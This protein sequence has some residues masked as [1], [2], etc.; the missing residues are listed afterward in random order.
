MGVASSTPLNL[1]DKKL[2]E[3]NSDSMSLKVTLGAGCYWGTENYVSN[4]WGKDGRV[5]S[6]AVGFMGGE[7]PNPTYENVCTG[8]TGHVEVLDVE[9]A[10]IAGVGKAALYEDLIRYYFQFHDPTTLNQQGNDQGTQYA[11]VIFVYD[12]EQRRIA[13]KVKDELSEHLEAGRIT[14]YIGNSI[15]TIIAPAS[16]FYRAPTNHQDYLTANP[17][18]Y[19]NHRIRFKKWPELK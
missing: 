19:C 17:G 12:E 2:D 1:P 5:V 15:S 9:I 8:K 10:D 11:S 16:E 13:T 18:G 7:K 4:K 3:V 6:S 14:G